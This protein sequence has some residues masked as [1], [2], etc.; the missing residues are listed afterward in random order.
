MTSGR[1]PT[2]RNR[3]I[4]TA[5]QGHGQGNRIKIPASRHD[6]RLFYEKMDDAV[7]VERTIGDWGITFLVQPVI[8]GFRHACTIDDICHLLAHVPAGDLIGI[9][10]F[11]LRQPTRK[12]QSLRPS[13]GRLA[14]YADTGKHRGRAI[15][16][17]AQQPGKS[18]RWSRSL[19]PE[20]AAEF[21]R[22]RV[23]GHGIEEDRRGFTVT[24]TLESIRTT[25]LYHT[26]LHELGH[27][28]DYRSKVTDL[29]KDQADCD[30]RRD[31][32][33]A[34]PPREREEFVHHYAEE[35]ASRLRNEDIIPFDRRDRPA[36]LKKTASTRP[37]SIPVSIRKGVPPQYGGRGILT[38]EIDA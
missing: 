12:Q 4:G 23:H 10:L 6:D 26:V 17:D 9:D 27:H 14:Y 2:R 11:L 33:F 13:W 3:N 32:Y 28:V 7:A 31:I 37:G 18:Y 20:D 16:L 38:P 29:A 15:F 30:R 34:R 24:P 35:Q 22:L 25:Q 36:A 19:T 5:K 8:A 1:N 21:D